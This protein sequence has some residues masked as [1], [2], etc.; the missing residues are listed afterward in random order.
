MILPIPGGVTSSIPVSVLALNA[1]VQP[2]GCHGNRFRAPPGAF[3]AF[4]LVCDVKFLAGDTAWF[5]AAGNSGSGGS[6][7]PGGKTKCVVQCLPR[8]QRTPW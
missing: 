1:D 3:V 6:C 7:C 8:E 5:F 2:D 4:Q